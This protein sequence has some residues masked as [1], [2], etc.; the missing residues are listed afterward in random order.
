MHPI[1][2]V[3]T[4][5]LIAG[6]RSG[7]RPPSYLRPALYT[8]LQEAL[9]IGFSVVAGLVIGIVY[10]MPRLAG[11][12]PPGDAVALAQELTEQL[13]Q[14]WSGLALALP[15]FLLIIGF[16]W[17]WVRVVEGRPFR[18]IGLWG[19][20]R[21]WK[22]MRGMVWA[23]LLFGLSLGLAAV[24]GNLHWAGFAPAGV[25]PALLWT[26]LTL[27]FYVIQGPAEEV[28]ARG[29]LLPAL[30]ARGGLWVGVLVSSLLFAAGHLLNPN[31]SVLAVVNLFLYGVFAA[32][33]ALREECLWGIF[34]FHA[35][36]NWAQGS[37]FGLEVSGA[38][39]SPAPLFKLV[40]DGPAWWAG[41]AIGPE[42]GLVVT[43]TTLLGIAA[44]LWWPARR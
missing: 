16:T 9:I 15:Q 21:L 10:L 36:W 22:G 19:T 44:A 34:G 12:A 41:G 8:L 30:G 43:L 29:Y 33:Y 24:T 27:G 3:S 25:G 38:N 23:L 37:V 26:I 17:F 6:A 5:Q 4:N 18:S 28:M 32:L 40:T 2:D 7:K 11:G 14:G 39:L 20:G 1:F 42:G 35:A 31:L 13:S